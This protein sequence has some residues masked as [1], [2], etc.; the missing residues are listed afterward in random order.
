[1]AEINDTATVSVA[2][3]EEFSALLRRLLVTLNQ[4]TLA[5]D[6]FGDLSGVGVEDVP[7]CLTMQEAVKGLDDIYDGL[8]RWSVA[9]PKHAPRG[10]EARS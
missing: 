9:W 6:H 1:M 4:L 5:A 7:A 10:E 8:D 3:D 2:T